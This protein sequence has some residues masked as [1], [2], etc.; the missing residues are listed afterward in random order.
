MAGGPG[1][2]LPTQ[3]WE[4]QK[5]KKLVFLSVVDFLFNVCPLTMSLLPTTLA[6]LSEPGGWEGAH[7]LP[8]LWQIS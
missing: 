5:L 3:F 7:A 1:G 8:S 2:Q 4:E 6:G